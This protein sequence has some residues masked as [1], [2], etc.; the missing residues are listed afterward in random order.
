MAIVLPLFTLAQKKTFTA[1]QI[2]KGQFP[3][4]FKP[5][6]EIEGWADDDH[7]IESRSDNN[8]GHVLMSVNAVSGKAVP[9]INKEK[10]EAPP[11]V[12]PD[13]Q[14]VTLSP[15]GKYAAY[16]KNNN[17]FVLEIAGNKETAL[18]SDG[19]DVILNGYAS[20]VYYEE[21]LGR[22]SNYKAF[23][24]SPDSR[25]IA[26][27][28]FDNSEV[29]LFPIY[30]ADGQHGFLEEQHYPK[31][32]D[33][34]PQVRI[35]I[36][37]VNGGSPVWAEF[38]AANDQYFGPVFWTPG[39]NLWIQWMNRRQDSLIIYEV[40]KTNGRREHIYTETQPTWIS[41]EDQD[42]FYFLK[43]NSGVII[44]SDKDGWEN[45]YL[46]DMKGK[47]INQVT[48]GN[49]WGTTIL[50]VDEKA[51]QL[52]VKA[53]KD[54]TARFDVYKVPFNGKNATRLTTG[55]YS[56]DVVN[57]SPKGKYFITVYSNLSTPPSMS[58]IDGKGKQVRALGSTKTA[59]LDNYALPRNRYVTV[60]SSDG[61]FDL[62]MIIT[63]P[64]NFDSTKKYP[65]WISVYGGPD[66]GTVYDR[67]RPTGGFTQWWAQEG[68]IQVTMDNRSSG[69]FGKT[70]MN[71][72][73][74][75]MGIWELDDY[76]TCAKWLRSQSWAE[77]SKIGINGGSFGGYV[78]CM[79]LTYGADVFTHGIAN[80]SVTDWKLYDT[81]YTERFMITP[82]QNPEGYRKTSVL[83][84]A[85]KYKGVLRIVHGTADDNVHMQ[86][87]IQFINALQDLNKSFELMMYPNQRH[88]FNGAKSAHSISE[89]RRFVYRH[90]L[91]R[92]EPAEL[93]KGER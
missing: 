51:R 26:F 14:N 87:S 72:I 54:N 81:H 65:V 31:A 43:D 66:A 85:N 32:G 90:L 17:L 60:K 35:G 75:Q 4:I 8:G 22:S 40:N 2:F 13:A 44:K 20:W 39:N 3:S 33:K 38:N 47:F 62:P 10:S 69:H 82:Q 58:L 37:S 76:I 63:Y 78:T 52:F 9:Y 21:I 27:M 15:D 34:N 84:Y 11:P 5:L 64:L 49:Y 41:L 91:E 80:Y 88:G 24:W 71:Y 83:T 92:D 74:K 86:N 28:R 45:L 89:T 7:Y 73:F 36:S 6:P 56:H 70:G 57:M 59:E 77:P 1:N 50:Q 67:W 46:H 18:T 29:P 61:K 30:I 42:R 23:W 55:E 79:A 19:S 12:V 25:N 68:I 16:T 53:R 48:N 93:G